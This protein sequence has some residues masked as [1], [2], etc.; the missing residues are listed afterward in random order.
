MIES[1][2]VRAACCVLLAI[3]ATCDLQ[4]ATGRIDREQPNRG[5]GTLPGTGKLEA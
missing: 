5:L 4:L 2:A 1:R 3:W